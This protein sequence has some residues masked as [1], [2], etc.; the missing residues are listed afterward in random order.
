MV[1]IPIGEHHGLFQHLKRTPERASEVTLLSALNLI[2]RIRAI[3]IE[4][5]DLSNVHPNWVKLMARS[6][7][8]RTN[9]QT[10]RLAPRQW[11]F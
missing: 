3:G 2:E 8:R 5:I 10:A 6:A 11:R 4:N 1:T 9:W 7:K